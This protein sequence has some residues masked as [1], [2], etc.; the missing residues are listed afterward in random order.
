MNEQ[1]PLLLDDDGAPPAR[2]LLCGVGGGGVNAVNNYLAR[3]SGPVDTLSVEADRRALARSAARRKVALLGA[4]GPAKAWGTGGDPARGKTLALGAT[5]ELLATLAGT[6]LMFLAASLGGGT[7]SGAAP[8]IANL[9]AQ[10]GILTIAVVTMPRRGEGSRATERARQ[11]L[12]DIRAQADAVLV[13]ENDRIFAAESV[14]VPLLDAFRKADEVLARAVIAL[15]EIIHGAGYINIDFADVERT[16]RMRGG[17]VLGIGRGR[18]PDRMRDAFAAAVEHPF[19]GGVDLSRAKAALINLRGRPTGADMKVI[20]ELPLS[21]G[22]EQELKYGIIADESLGDEIELTI[23]ASG[24]PVADAPAIAAPETKAAAPQ[25]PS[26]YMGGASRESTPSRLAASAAGPSP[27]RA[28]PSVMSVTPARS[29]A[30]VTPVNAARLTPPRA[31]S[32]LPALQTGTPPEISSEDLPP[33]SEPA[34]AAGRPEVRT[35]VIT[36]LPA[37]DPPT[38]PPGGDPREVP[39]FMRRRRET[40]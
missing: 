14:P 40:V 7:G 10:A 6:D 34:R 3:A 28:G 19:V 2:L 30:P 15:T 37:I 1:M 11:A 18:G 13:V 24:L 25:V 5:N 27:V 26:Y 20:N 8:V 9:A 17:A 32:A 23:I 29:A 39:A 21:G 31:G 35:E 16:L 38:P 22:L 33:V 12:A 36:S 4:A